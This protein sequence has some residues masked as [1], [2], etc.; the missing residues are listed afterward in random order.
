[1]G[2]NMTSRWDSP[3]CAWYA[4]MV[5][6][7][8]YSP[9]APLFGWRLQASKAVMEQRYLLSSRTMKA[10][11]SACSFGANGW[12]L[13]QCAQLNGIIS[14]AAFNF[15]VQLPSEIILVFRERS[16]FS[17]IFIYRIICVS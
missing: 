11:P 14:E 15:I 5:N 1:M 16:L 6:R 8:A 9:C 12:I 17:S 3:R 13:L 4:L 7:P 2:I 10:Y